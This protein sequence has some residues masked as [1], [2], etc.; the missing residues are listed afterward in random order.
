MHACSGVMQL[1][2]LCTHLVAHIPALGHSW[3]SWAPAEQ[4]LLPWLLFRHPQRGLQQQRPHIYVDKQWHTL[5]SARQHH[6]LA[7][8]RSAASCWLTLSAVLHVTQETALPP[9]I[10]IR[11]FQS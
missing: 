3:A 5:Y 9:G 4:L 7:S 11:G 1:A 10:I 6:G 2:L 8:R